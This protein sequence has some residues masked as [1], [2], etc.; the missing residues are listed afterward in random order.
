MSAINEQ[1]II[2]ALAENEQP[3]EQQAKKIIDKALKLKGL[4]LS[5]TA[6]LL[7]CKDK[8]MTEKMLMAAKK[9][10]EKIY[11]N[12]LVLFAPL[13]LSN[14]CTN[15]CLYCGFRAANKELK[16][17]ALSM[18]E[19]RR[20]VEILE[21]KGHKRLLLVAGEH[22]NYT[23]IEYLTQAIQTV[24]ETKV[25]RGEIRR[26]NANVAPFSVKEFRELKEAGIGTYQLFQET[27]H[28]ETYKKMH[29]SGMKADFEWRLTGMD[30]AQQAGIDD[31][32][33]GVLFGLHDYKFEV[34]ALL[35]HA[36]H[37]EEKFG[38][39]PHTI[40][41][42]RI[43]PALGAPAALEP[44][45]PV[46][47]EEFRKLVA[48]IRLSVPYTGMILSTRENAPFRNELFNYGISQI[49]AASRTNPGGYADE[50]KK[51]FPEEEQFA[52]GDTRELE[53]VVV[54]VMR[55]RFVPSFC[56]ACYRSGRTGKKFMRLAKLGSIQKFCTPNALSTLKE[57][58]L[59]YASPETKRIGEKLIERELK[60][61]KEKKIR[62]TT[63]KKL[64]RVS[65]GE[66]DV[67]I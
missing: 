47:D 7:Q 37:L 3:S 48:V 61:I 15:D 43:E 49:S 38:V 53:E 6:A 11:G 10:K 67:Y 64:E 46:S 26:V 32:G 57:Y 39:G 34:L 31:V 1:K 45:A 41:V 19:L 62:E 33:V 35:Q 66:R 8:K 65:N 55:Q 54:E 29:P 36:R 18:N 44:P 22:P 56:T 21:K 25:G 52:L 23:G 28:R 40:S 9:V 5:E 30:R 50:Q 51:H 60:K 58:L 42:P 14:Y 17:K 2:D 12:R 59:D 16:R 63:R 13:Y 4:E 27:Y 24:Y 20:E